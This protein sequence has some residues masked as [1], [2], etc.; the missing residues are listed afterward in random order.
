RL[1]WQTVIAFTF[2]RLAHFH[3]LILCADSVEKLALAWLKSQV[4]DPETRAKLTPHHALG[5]KRPSFHNSFLRTFN[6][7]NVHLQ[8]NSIEEV[9]ATGIRTADGR[10]HALDVLIL[11]TGFKVTD[12]DAMPK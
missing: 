1:T 8:T 4:K 2:P 10:E 12:T 9:T 11:A 5:C 7:S 6:L 3:S